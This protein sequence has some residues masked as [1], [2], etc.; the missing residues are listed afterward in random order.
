ME[1]CWVSQGTLRLD[2]PSDQ[3]QGGWE[4]VGSQVLIL[5][6]SLSAQVLWLCKCSLQVHS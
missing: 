4:E 3:A 5:Q 6:A 1:G 2:V